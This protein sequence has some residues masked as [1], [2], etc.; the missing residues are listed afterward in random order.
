M[1]K[2]LLLL[3]LCAAGALAQGDYHVDVTN[4]AGRTITFY[5]YTGFRVCKCL[6]NTQTAKI[7]NR[8]GGDVKLFSSTDCTGS[9]TPL[10]QGKTQYS[11]QWVYS[12]SFGKS[13]IS[14]RDPT[15]CPNYFG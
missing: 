7:Y 1:H 5:D 4:N 8:D 14:S 6:K 15:S 2:S 3:A 13:G 12:M 9:Y 11:A 10:A